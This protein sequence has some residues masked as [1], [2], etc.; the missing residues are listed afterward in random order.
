MEA[1]GRKHTCKA[2]LFL[3]RIAAAVTAAGAVGTKVSL[4]KNLTG[5]ANNDID[6]A[7]SWRRH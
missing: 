5:A 7:S 2:N 6:D 3:L 4:S 1:G